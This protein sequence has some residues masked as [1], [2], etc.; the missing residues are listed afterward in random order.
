MFGGSIS[1]GGYRTLATLRHIDCF[2]QV[3]GRLVDAHSLIDIDAVIRVRIITAIIVLIIRIR[4]KNVSVRRHLG[5]L[6]PSTVPSYSHLL[7]F[8]IHSR[9]GATAQISPSHYVIRGVS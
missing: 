7:L 8:I 4:G 3:A 5:L 2:A 6:L 9:S 1:I